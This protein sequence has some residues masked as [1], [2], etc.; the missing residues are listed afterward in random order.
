MSSKKEPRKDNKTKDLKETTI[1]NK[2]KEKKTI[3][4][5][6]I[7][8][9][10]S[11]AW[12]LSIFYVIQ[13]FLI[14]AFTIPTSSMVSTLLIGDFIFVNKFVYGAQT[15][16]NIPLTGIKLPRYRFPA[17][18]EPHQ[19]DVVVFRFPHPELMKNQEGLDYI[20]RCVAV[21]GQ[22][23]EVRKKVLYVDGKIFN[24][25]FDFP[26]IHFDPNYISESG[27]F[28]KTSGTG[29][30]FGPFRIPARG[31]TIRIKNDNLD[32]IKYLALRDQQKFEIQSD[33]IYINGSKTVDYIVGQDYYFMMGDN[34]DNSLD[35]RFWGPVPRDHIMGEGLLIYWSNVEAAKQTNLILKVFS[36][37]NISRVNW[38]RIGTIIR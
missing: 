9:V 25:E 2:S 3:K 31:D 16:E 10:K 17:F 13:T 38:G 34:R 22:T 20:K 32:L 8:T 33:G 11:F 18:K 28:P 36:T 14:Q 6:F 1:K 37:L 21:A 19:G 15:P 4:E 24:D 29:D 26:G 23:L 12:A 35:S 7:E 5:K 27:A 30:N